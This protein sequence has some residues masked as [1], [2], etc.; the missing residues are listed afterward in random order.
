MAGT[1]C[2][3]SEDQCQRQCDK[4]EYSFGK[5]SRPAFLVT[6]E[7]ELFTRSSC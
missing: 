4:I 7:I 2:R 6:Q 3:Q 1:L 5:K